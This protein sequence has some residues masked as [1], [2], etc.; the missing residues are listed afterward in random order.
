MLVENL[1]K[2]ALMGA[3]WVMYLLIALS[4]ISI[5]AMFERWLFFKKHTD[6]SDALGEV[7]RT[8]GEGEELGDVRDRLEKRRTVEGLVI[9][10]ALGFSRTS[11]QALANAVDSEMAKRRKELERGLNFLG[12]IGSNAPFIGLFGTVIGVIEAFH[13][14]GAGADDAAMGNVMAA[15]A[16]ALVATGVGLFV[17][18][19]AVVAYN[20]FQ[21]KVADIEGNV[22]A[23]VKQLCAQIEV[24]ASGGEL[25]LAPPPRQSEPSLDGAAEATVEP[26]LGMA[27]E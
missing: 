19:P 23:L 25:S 18:I 6:D 10:R 13:H 7:L 26:S 24:A 5:G 14:L 15:I 3:S 1:M 16:E 9:A 17:A 8:L 2:L 4:V 21:A 11:P 27:T 12:T 22:T 20:V